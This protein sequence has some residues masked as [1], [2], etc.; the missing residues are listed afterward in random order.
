MAWLAERYSLPG[1]QALAE[2]TASHTPSPVR[3][4]TSVTADALLATVRSHWG[5][6]KQLH[7]VMDVVFVIGR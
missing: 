2:V 4:V 6:A 1:L 3:P 7:W 5:I